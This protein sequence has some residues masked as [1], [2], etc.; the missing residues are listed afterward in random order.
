KNIAR[1]VRVYAMT[2]VAVAST[3]LVAAVAPLGRARS[4]RR[5]V[6]PASAVA[7]MC[8]AVAGWWLWPKGTPPAGPTEAPVAGSGLLSVAETK[9]A[10]RLSIVV[11]PFTNLS[12]D[13]DQEYSADGVT[14]DLTTDLSR[15]SDS[16]VIA[17][18]TAFTYKGKP[19]D[20]KQIGRELNV[21]YVLEGSVRRTGDQVRV[22]AQLIDTESGAHVWADRF[23]TDRANLAEAQ[24]E[25]TGRLARILNTELVKDVS[26]RIEQENAADPDAHD[27]V[28][29]GWA[30]FNRPFSVAARQEA[31]RAFERALQIDPRSSHAKIGVARVL[32]VNRAD[33]WNSASFQQEGAQKDVA[34]AERLL[35]EAI[36]SDSTS[37]MAYSI[38]GLLRRLQSRLTESRVAFDKAIVL[39]PNNDWATRQLSWTLLFLGEPGDAIALGQKSLRLNPRDPKIYNIYLQLGWCYL[40][41]KKVDEAID[42]FIKGRT[43]NPRDWFFSYGLAGALALKGDLDGAKAALAESFKLKPEVN[44]LAQWYA[45]L[46]WTSKTSAP[47]FWMLQDKTLN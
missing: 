42:T 11:L 12:N 24:S 1:P 19:I 22:N 21:R 23:D 16:F 26:R 37:S 47:Q 39:D 25:I 15:I 30:W 6:I 31:L 8:I 18:N 4:L 2:A 10:P 14:D 38:I 40:F 41:S 35:S 20:A 5:I 13:P 27:L 34:R 3:P 17:R 44:S 33:A 46:P 28:M 9:Q 32:V 45:Y 36:E 43:A 29:R 7:L